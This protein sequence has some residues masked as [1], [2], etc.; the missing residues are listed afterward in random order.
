MKTVEKIEKISLAEQTYLRITSMIVRGEFPAGSRLAEEELSRRFG[1][2]RTPV[3]ETLRRLAEAELIELLPG[4]GARVRQASA[5]EIGDLF[6]C[7]TMIECLALTNAAGR[8]PDERLA[9]LEKIFADLRTDRSRAVS[10]DEEFHTLIADSCSNCCLGEEL[11]KL[12]LRCAPYRHL[13]NY[14]QSNF[15]PLKERLKL[16]RLVRARD[17]SRAR[18]ELI[19]H[20]MS[21]ARV[22]ET[23]DEAAATEKHEAGATL[24]VP[25]RGESPR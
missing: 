9:E 14:M 12:I 25:D 19:A 17:W 11:K 2:S 15:D 22:A 10:A 5:K 1:V 20:I 3:R 13:H 7:R 4:R 18:S 16:V 8:I 24:P 6:E 21:A 23:H